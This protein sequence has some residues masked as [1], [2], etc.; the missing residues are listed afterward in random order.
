M[1]KKKFEKKR[2][3]FYKQNILLAYMG[4]LY[5]IRFGIVIVWFFGYA[6][7]LSFNSDCFI[8]IL[9]KRPMNYFKIIELTHLFLLQ[10]YLYIY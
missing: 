2:N 8:D 1:V 6:E 7:L 5:R 10:S 3:I 4:F 9:C